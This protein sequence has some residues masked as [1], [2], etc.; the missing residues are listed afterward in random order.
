ML[1]TQRGNRLQYLCADLVFRVFQLIDPLPDIKVAEALE[2]ENEG[3]ADDDAGK[4]LT[5]KSKRRRREKKVIHH[6]M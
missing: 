1:F 6:Q 3:T 5:G 2:G 4:G